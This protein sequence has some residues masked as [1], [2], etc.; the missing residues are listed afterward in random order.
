MLL[1]SILFI[2]L[3]LISATFLY[4]FFQGLG[5]DY[6]PQV[7]FV[8]CKK[9]VNARFFAVAGNELIN[10]VSGTIIDSEVTKPEW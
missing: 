10:P 2:C 4:L 7:T 8:V 1:I 5:E 3:L 9:R 6:D